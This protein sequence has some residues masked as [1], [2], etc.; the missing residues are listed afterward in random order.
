MD[1]ELICVS[2]PAATLE[3]DC[4]FRA[5]AWLV[6][7][8]QAGPL[9]GDQTRTRIPEKFASALRK[10]FENFLNATDAAK[11]IIHPCT[12]SLGGTGAPELHEQ[13]KQI[14]TD[15]GVAASRIEERTKIV[16]ERIGRQ[17]LSRDFRSSDSDPWKELKHL[18]NFLS[19]KLQ[20]VFPSEMQA[21]TE[22]R[23]NQD[24][25]FG[26][27]KNKAK[28]DKAVKKPIMLNA[29]DVSVP[30][31]VFCDCSGQSLSQIS[32][33]HRTNGPDARGVVIVQAAGALPY[34]RGGP[35]TFEGAL[36]M[37][38]VNHQ[39]PLIHD[40]GQLIRFPATCERTGEA[41]LHQSSLQQ[42][43]SNW[44]TL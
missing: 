6:D 13:V 31:G 39:D 40:I 9:R 4:G 5:V 34:L 19:P 7:A 16:I 41:I 15:R 36:A 29:E 26:S 27:K 17:P 3:N 38:V 8:L 32:I 12:L 23:L 35:T 25:S 24:K 10:V 33:G 44:G 42:S 22:R 43:S 14:L 28:G 20:L 30:D 2:Q 11:C 18:A 37:I 1:F 21:A